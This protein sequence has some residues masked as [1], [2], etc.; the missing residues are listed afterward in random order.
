MSE[1][2][3]FTC[4]LPTLEAT[5]ALAE[6]LARVLAPGDLLLLT[7]PLGAGKTFFTGALCHAWGLPEEEPVTSPTFALVQEYPT[8][9]ALNHAD[10]YRLGSEEEVFELGLAERRLEGQV[11]V[12]EW[13]APYA[14]V[15]GGDPIELVLTVFPRTAQIRAEGGRSSE[16]VRALCQGEPSS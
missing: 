15:L 13:G 2:Q 11:V 10:L 9:P 3:I 4:E 5:I 12:A 8:E 14:D 16:V 6:R 7:G 1:P